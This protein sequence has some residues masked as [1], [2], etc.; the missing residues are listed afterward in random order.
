MDSPSRERTVLQ[1][2]RPGFT[3]HGRVVR[4]AHVVVS[5]PAPGGDAPEPPAE[6][7]EDEGGGGAG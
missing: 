4:P 3:L 1:V 7:G 5:R 2:V 6:P